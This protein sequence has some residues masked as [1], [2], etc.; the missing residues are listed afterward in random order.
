LV[1]QCAELVTESDI[2]DVLKLRN[3]KGIGFGDLN[4]I[5]DVISSKLSHCKYLETDDAHFIKIIQIALFENNAVPDWVNSINAGLL[6]AISSFNSSVFVA[7]WR[8]SKIDV[9]VLSRLVDRLEISDGIECL[10]AENTPKD[11]S[12]PIADHL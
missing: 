5:W 10:I 2:A 8:W 4:V 3:L 7:I 1:T 9:S 12:K 11:L 6:G